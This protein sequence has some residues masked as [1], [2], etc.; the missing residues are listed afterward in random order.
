MLNVDNNH[1]LSY[2]LILLF[3]M[4]VVRYVQST[5]NN[6][7]A[8]SLQYLEK[9]RRNDV[10]FLQEDKYQSLLQSNTIVFGGYSQTW[11]KY[12]LHQQ[13]QQQQQQQQKKKKKKVAISL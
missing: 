2:K 1:K 11:T 5:Q 13:Q 10:D 7:F 9:E 3:L 4:G 12:P 8:I 6:K